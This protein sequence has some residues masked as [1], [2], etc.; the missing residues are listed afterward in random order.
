MISTTIEMIGK[1][2]GTG[3]Y[4][5]TAWVAGEEL[6]KQTSDS[7]IYDSIDTDPAYVLQW[8]KD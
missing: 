2:I 3:R 6:S 4:E 7:T 8:L 5:I 1:V